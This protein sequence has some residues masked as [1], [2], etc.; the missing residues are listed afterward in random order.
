MAAMVGQVPPVLVDALV[1]EMIE[2][3]MAEVI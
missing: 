1:V 3:L 2:Q